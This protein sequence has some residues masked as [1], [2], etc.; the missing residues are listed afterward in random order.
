MKK[1]SRAQQDKNMG[2]SWL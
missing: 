1:S 2:Q